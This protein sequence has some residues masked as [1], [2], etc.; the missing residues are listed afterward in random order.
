MENLQWHITPSWGQYFSTPPRCGQISLPL[1]VLAANKQRQIG[2]PRSLWQKCP[3]LS[4]NITDLIP[5]H[6]H[7]S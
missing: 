3:N 6:V 2:S 4:Y 5:T 1:K 7:V